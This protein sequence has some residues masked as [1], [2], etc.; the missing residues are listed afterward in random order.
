MNQITFVLT[1]FLYLI[2]SCES[3]KPTQTDPVVET[4]KAL[5]ESSVENLSKSYRS[6]DLVASLYSELAAKSEELKELESKIGDVLEKPT[7]VNQDFIFYDEKSKSYYNTAK[8]YTS[9]FADSAL[10][11]QILKIIESSESNYKAKAKDYEYL[12]TLINNNQVS[13]NDKHSIL[14]MLV[15]LPEIQNF[16]N[17]NAPAKKVYN[18]LLTEQQKTI[19]Q[20]ENR[21]PKY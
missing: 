7:T 11:K 17:K 8:Q 21:T 10:K 3:P 5:Q 6:E 20:I 4:P 9:R 2:Y 1:L 16:Q 15:T 19:K 14:K 13:L 18:D 12:M